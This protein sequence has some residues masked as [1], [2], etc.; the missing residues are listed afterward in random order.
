M[1]LFAPVNEEASVEHRVDHLVDS[2]SNRSVLQPQD[3]RRVC[4]VHLA[5]KVPGREHLTEFFNAEREGPDKAEVEFV[6][7]DTETL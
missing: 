3:L 4:V 7:L 6:G 2:R 5:I 1:G